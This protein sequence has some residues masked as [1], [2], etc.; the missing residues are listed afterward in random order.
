MNQAYFSPGDHCSNAIIHC[1]RQAREYIDI[2][3][4]TISDNQIS[5]AII[6]ASN[7]GINIRIITDNDKQHDQGSDIL[8]LKHAG[9]PVRTDFTAA[10]MHH[11]F[12]VFDHKIVLSGSYNWT[13]SARDE[14]YENIIIS[15][16]EKLCTEFSEEF[17]KLWEKFKTE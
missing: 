1:L 4:F 6:E 9:I 5:D 17:E 3:V 15:D 10:H 8:N 16:S 12:A 2:C 7:R 14:N 11:K 13:L